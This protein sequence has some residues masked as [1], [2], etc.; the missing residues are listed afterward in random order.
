MVSVWVKSSSTKL[1]FSLQIPLVS[2]P[3]QQSPSSCL[4]W[5]EHLIFLNR[6]AQLKICWNFCK[7][8]SWKQGAFWEVG[9]S[10][11]PLCPSLP[12]PS[13]PLTK[14][15]TGACAS[16]PQSHPNGSVSFV[17]K[18]EHLGDFG[19]T[20][21]GQSSLKPSVHRIHPLQMYTILA[22]NLRTSSSRKRSDHGLRDKKAEQV[23]KDKRP[24]ILPPL[25]GGSSLR[26][27]P[28]IQPM[29][30]CTAL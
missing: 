14:Q 24:S 6:D 28:P 22:L 5:I 19:A 15:L 10:I 26:P 13:P 16:H 2:P 1:S 8:L 27:V 21:C 17:N 25:S 7:L 29:T 20:F 11:R 12:V 9:S 23:G 4:K 3:W 18:Q 30:H